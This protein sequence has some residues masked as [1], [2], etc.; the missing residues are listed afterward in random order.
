MPDL[1]PN[2]PRAMRQLPRDS[3][4]RPV[5][6]FVEWIDGVPDFRIMN[7]KNLV[8]ALREDLCWVCGERL[9][10]N[11]LARTGYSG[12]FVAGPMCLVN[13]TSAEPPNHY[14]CAEWSAKACPFLSMPKKVRR[15]ANKPAGAEDAPGFAIMR[16]PGVAALITTGNWSVFRPEGGGIL[17][18]FEAVRDVEWICEGREATA[19]EVAASID[20]GLPTL[21]AM[22]NE[23]GPEAVA[24]LETMVRMAMKWVPAI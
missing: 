6:F 9:T 20:S 12:T 8:R 19:E 15:E 13:G 4:G 1:P 11:R 16:N 2:M 18:H 5:P 14:A 10:R 22:A 21:Y 23:E 17:I 24:A 7:S 3:V